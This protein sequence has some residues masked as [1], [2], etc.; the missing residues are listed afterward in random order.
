MKINPKN[1]KYS[2]YHDQISMVD[3]NRFGNNCK[4]CGKEMTTKESKK[5]IGLCNRCERI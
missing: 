2:K 5:P 4:K 3:L 1:Y